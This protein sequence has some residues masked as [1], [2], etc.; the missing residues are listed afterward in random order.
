MLIFANEPTARPAG[1]K[2]DEIERR[3]RERLEK[4]GHETAE[5]TAA[6]VCLTIWR[7]GRGWL[8]VLSD[9]ARRDRE[10]APADWIKA[11]K[12]LEHLADEMRKCL[13]GMVPAMLSIYLQGRLNPQG[14]KRDKEGRAILRRAKTP[15]D[16]AELLS[17]F[18]GFAEFVQDGRKVG[19]G[20]PGDPM[21]KMRRGNFAVQLVLLFKEHGLPIATAEGS[22]LPRIARL[23]YEAFGVK[24]DA[25]DDI[26]ALL[27][28]Q[29]GGQPKPTPEPPSAAGG[30]ET[31]TPMARAWWGGELP[32]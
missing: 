4:D 16:V 24:A 27:P 31:P 32:E 6:D 26:C 28:P 30:Q 21:G 8:E 3:L 29:A 10:G 20:A 23:T 5:A 1:E 9:P 7:I 11:A 15:P 19:P 12:R 25:R 22:F 18:E 17:L 2:W 13:N 14:L